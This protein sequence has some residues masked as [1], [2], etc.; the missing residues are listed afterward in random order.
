ML[1]NSKETLLLRTETVL[2]QWALAIA[3]SY[4]RDTPN[5]ALTDKFNTLWVLAAAIINS[6]TLALADQETI[7]ATM[8]RVGRLLQVQPASYGPF[9]Q[10]ISP[11]YGAF[12]THNSL[13]GLQGGSVGQY[14]HLDLATYT[15]I[16]NGALTDEIALTSDAIDTRVVASTIEV[17]QRYRITNGGVGGNKQIVVY[18]NTSTTITGL[19]ENLTDQTRGTYVL[20][21]RVYTPDAGGGAGGLPFETLNFEE[22][23]TKQAAE[24]WQKG[25]YYK[26]VAP[27]YADVLGIYTNFLCEFDGKLPEYSVGSGGIEIS[28]LRVT[29][30]GVSYTLV[31]SAP[32]NNSKTNVCDIFF[33]SQTGGPFV[34]TSREYND[35]P[36]GNNGAD[37][38]KLL[39]RKASGNGYELIAPSGGSEWGGIT[40]TLDSQT[41]LAAAL[42]GKANQATTYTKAETDA[43]VVG[44]LDDRGNFDASGGAYP[45]SGGSGA[46]GAILKG[47][48]WIISVAGTLPTGQV[49]EVGDQIRALV[50]TPANTQTNWAISQSNIGYVPEN[51]AN[52]TTNPAS[53][54]SDILFFTAR[55]VAR[56][57]NEFWTSILP[58]KT[59]PVNTDGFLIN[60]SEDGGTA[61]IKLLSWTNFK[62]ALAVI[63]Q[64][65]LNSGTNIKTVNGNSLLG[66][67]DLTIS[68]GSSVN[69]LKESCRVMTTSNI[70]LSGLQ[71]I[72]GETLIAGD[73]VLVNAQLISANNGIYVVASGTW[74]RATDA[75]TAAL[76][77]H[78]AVIVR[79]TQLGP[80][81]PKVYFQKNKIN[82]IGTDAVEFLPTVKGVSETFIQKIS[83]DGGIS[84]EDYSFQFIDGLFVSYFQ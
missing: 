30:R 72:S 51:S 15:A 43:L 47:D 21:T 42:D 67:G 25:V 13:A 61:T 71:T 45:T 74:T 53:Y 84:F 20:S 31:P 68:G 44:L 12:G 64:P 29:Q 22:A 7:L 6:P 33:V 9:T 10:V 32:E 19:A 23:N 14:Y 55:A 56:F 82:T 5:V 46:A 73:R 66:S 3:E 52:K 34:F 40:G 69:F 28:D 24:T 58:S 81:W 54:A 65:T 39:A 26:V 60:D 35:L 79:V 8:V 4:A 75:N 62:N 37:N 57:L 38:G 48:I 36:L 16:Q 27:L 70:T 49:V 63:F 59:T 50:D 1:T 78:C 11:I 76:L 17:G 77:T 18:G 80:Q 41:D 2:K 83:F